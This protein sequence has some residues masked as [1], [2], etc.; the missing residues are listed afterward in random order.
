MAGKKENPNDVVFNVREILFQ[1]AA[2]AAILPFIKDIANHQI[3]LAMTNVCIAASLLLFD[4]A[5]KKYE[6]LGSTGLGLCLLSRTLVEKVIYGDF[7]SDWLLI[8]SMGFLAHAGW[9][10]IARYLDSTKK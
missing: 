1:G 10:G 2:V 7:V 8:A 5:E 9:A 6:G 3:E 4:R